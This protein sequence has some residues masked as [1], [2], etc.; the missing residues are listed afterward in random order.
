MSIQ[1][2]RTVKFSF[3]SYLRDVI[4]LVVH[5]HGNLIHAPWPGSSSGLCDAKRNVSVRCVCVCVC[6]CV[7]PYVAR[8][9]MWTKIKEIQVWIFILM[10]CV[11]PQIRIVVV[12][13]LIVWEL[14]CSNQLID[15]VQTVSDSVLEVN[16][17]IRDNMC[18]VKSTTSQD[19]P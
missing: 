8:S 12:C 4:F 18:V 19:I 3:D 17:K 7:E 13:Q 5:V 16:F 15:C 9:D 11:F 1:N 2:K 10:K 14:M 6:V